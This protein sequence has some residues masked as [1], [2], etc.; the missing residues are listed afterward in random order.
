RQ[1]IYSMPIFPSRV[2]RLSNISRS[3]ISLPK[4]IFPPSASRSIRQKRDQAC[5]GADASNR[6]DGSIESERIVP[7]SGLELRVEGINHAG[8]FRLKPLQRFY[9]KSPFFER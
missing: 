3:S 8:D 9:D 7:K 2:V 6:L 5:L 1:K 4:V